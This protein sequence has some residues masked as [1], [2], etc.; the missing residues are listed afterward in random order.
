MYKNEG[1]Q[2]PAGASKRNARPTELRPINAND[3]RSEHAILKR[4]Q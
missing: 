4:Q 2:T 3:L 1:R